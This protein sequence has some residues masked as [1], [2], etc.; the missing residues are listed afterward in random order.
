MNENRFTHDLIVIGAG[1][2]GIAGARRAA[3]H[4]AKVAVIE[5]KLPGGTCVNVGCV[6]KKLM[7]HAGG[8]RHATHEASGYGYSEIHA[9]LDWGKLVQRREDYLRRLNGIYLGNLEK[10]GIDYIQGAARFSCASKVEVGDQ[11]LTAPHILIATGAKPQVPDVPGAELGIS[12]D[13]FFALTKQP[14]RV[15]I[16]GSGYIAVELAGLLRAL[17]SQVD[18]VIRRDA[19]LRSFDTMLSEV[20]LAEMKQAGIRVHTSSEITGLSKD[21]DGIRAAI[22]GNSEEL[23]AD[24]VIWAIGREPNTDGLN[25]AAAGLETNQRGFIETDERQNTPVEGIYAVGDVTG[26]AQLTPVAIAAARRWAERVFAEKDGYLDY[27]LIPTVVFS[28]PPIGTVGLS[29]AQAREKYGDEV[30]IYQ[31][32]FKSLYYA[33]IDEKVQSAMKLVT[34]G[35]DEKVV[36]CHVIG[37]GSD[38]MMQGFAVAIKM[39]AT[40]SDFDNTVAIHP[41]ASEELVT[42]V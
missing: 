22:N 1:S 28:H 3:K 5:N 29:E 25:L 30:K 41:T 35:A 19:V 38:E 8:L 6:P 13:G 24:E 39:G 27:N 15:V 33:L 17:G 14:E 18:L 26:R 7:W 40:K 12:S 9:E 34:V 32:Q 4:G 42:M 16:S 37:P 10:D 20:L 31:S 36:G 21:G 23:I 11:A 2:G